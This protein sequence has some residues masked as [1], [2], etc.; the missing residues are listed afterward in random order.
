MSGRGVRVP[1][2]VVGPTLVPWDGTAP[3][4]EDGRAAVT[5]S[6]GGRRMRWNRQGASGLRDAGPE[7]DASV[8]PVE[9]L[10]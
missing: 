3:D 4:R 10:R 6:E 8:A 5:S 9:D 1:M 2:R 7:A